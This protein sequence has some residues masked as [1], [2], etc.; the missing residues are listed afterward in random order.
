MFK[1]ILRLMLMG[2]GSLPLWLAQLLGGS[3]GIIALIFSKQFREL[4]NKNY[5]RAMDLNGIKQRPLMAAAA[6]GMLFMDSLWIWYN[7]EKAL[8]KTQF[9]NWE[10]VQRAMQHGRGLIILSP[11]LGGFE[12]IPRYIAQ[13][14]PATIMFRPARQEWLN[15]I[16][17]LGR[18]YPNMNFVPANLQGVRAM[19][20]ALKEGGAIALLPDQVPSSGDGV[21]ASFFNQNAYTTTLPARLANRNQTP[22]ILFSAIRKSLGQGWLVEVRLL[23]PFS[24]NSEEAAVQ[25]NQ[26]IEE[27]ILKAPEQFI[28]SYNRYKH[29]EG[30]LLPP[31]S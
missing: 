12:I 5:S 8:I 30:A 22:V 14:F 9:I 28:W 13:H 6:S 21:W 3:G 7:P 26:A 2:I 1:F 11:H 25:M 4:F 24:E 10:M 27:A 23:E 29:P 18:A 19:T 17:V 31:Q 16:V 20:R 15:E